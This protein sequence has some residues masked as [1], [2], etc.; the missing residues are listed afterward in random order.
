MK[1]MY[2]R[3]SLHLRGSWQSV[4]V[5][6]GNLAL[7]GG[8]LFKYS[9][10]LLVRKSTET[11]ECGNVPLVDRVDVFL[12]TELVSNGYDAYAAENI[13]IVVISM[14]YVATRNEL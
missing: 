5:Y 10:R 13:I 1:S 11:H 7:A 6:A 14:L 8:D 12:Q 2:T 4:L 3:K 9:F